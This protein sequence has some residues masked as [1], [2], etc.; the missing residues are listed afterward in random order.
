ML[1]AV[2]GANHHLGFVGWSSAEADGNQGAAAQGLGVVR[3]CPNQ[4]TNVWKVLT[5]AMDVLPQMTGTVTCPPVTG[6]DLPS[7]WCANI[8]DLNVSRKKHWLYPTIFISDLQISNTC[9]ESLDEQGINFLSEPDFTEYRP[10]PP[11]PTCGEGTELLWMRKCGLDPQ[12]HV[13]VL[14]MLC[15]RQFGQ[16]VF[17]GWPIRFSSASS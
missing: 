4:S 11:G 15:C 1:S 16:N 8:M 3:L 12:D 14:T 17:M 2:W 6:Q 10:P 5:A 13:R 9:Q 7:P